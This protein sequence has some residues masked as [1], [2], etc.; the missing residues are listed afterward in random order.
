MS[1][2]TL[3]LNLSKNVCW[4]KKAIHSFIEFIRKFVPN[5]WSDIQRVAQNWNVTG[6]REFNL[7]IEGEYFN[8][9]ST[10]RWWTFLFH[11]FSVLETLKRVTV[12]LMQ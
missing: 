5:Y 6:V 9:T 3:T 2:K 7:E 10:E 12:I 11:T 8:E 1:L 4:G